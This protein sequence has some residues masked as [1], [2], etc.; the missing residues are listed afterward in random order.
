MTGSKT[1]DA[2]NG[3]SADMVRRLAEIL[4]GISERERDIVILHLSEGEDLAEIAERTGM[5]KDTVRNMYRGAIRK[6]GELM[7]QDPAFSMPS[8]CTEG[9]G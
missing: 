8:L 2:D 9:P 7:G 3:I 1:K 4:R 5:T 6:I